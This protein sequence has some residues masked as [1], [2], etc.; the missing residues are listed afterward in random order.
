MVFWIFYLKKLKKNFNFK[1][2]NNGKEKILKFFFLL[3]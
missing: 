2:R 3:R 1:K